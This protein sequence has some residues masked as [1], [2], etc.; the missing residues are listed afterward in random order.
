MSVFLKHG[1]L[2]PVWG[3]DFNDCSYAGCRNESQGDHRAAEPFT[4]G[5]ARGG[6]RGRLLRIQLPYGFREPDQRNQR[7]YLRI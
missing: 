4:H 2:F 7:Q 3:G 5:F 1:K 6:R